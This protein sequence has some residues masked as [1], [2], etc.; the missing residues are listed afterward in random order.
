[1]LEVIATI[2]ITLLVLREFAALEPGARA[3]RAA[4]LLGWAAAPFLLV[5]AALFTVRVLGYLA[6]G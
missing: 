5:F 1:M 2:A 3:Q 6:N 4:R